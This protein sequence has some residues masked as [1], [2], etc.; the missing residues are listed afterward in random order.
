MATKSISPHDL[1]SVCMAKSKNYEAEKEWYEKMIKATNDYRF[2]Y[3]LA[4]L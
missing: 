4:N 2:I 3:G 1:L